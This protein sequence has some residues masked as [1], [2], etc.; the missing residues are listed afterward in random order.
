MVIV[1]GV[2]DYRQETIINVSKQ[3]RK[4]LRR[5]VPHISDTNVLLQLFDNYFKTRKN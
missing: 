4:Q 5:K 1:S 3:R 2:R